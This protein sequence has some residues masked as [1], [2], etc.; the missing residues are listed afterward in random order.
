MCQA[1]TQT[2][3]EYPAR[4][5]LIV[6]DGRVEWV[7]EDVGAAGL[8]VKGDPGRGLVHVLAGV[9]KKSA[10]LKRAGS[11][12]EKARSEARSLAVSTGRPV[13]VAELVKVDTGDP[14]QMLLFARYLAEPIQ[15]D[16][17][18][19]VAKGAVG[20]VIQLSGLR[21]VVKEINPLTP[22]GFDALQIKLADGLMKK[23]APVSRAE[24][25]KLLYSLDV[26]WVNSTDAE[27]RILSER[28]NGAMRQVAGQTWTGVR[29]TLYHTGE[30]I[31]DGTRRATINRWDMSI[32]ANFKQRDLEAIRR[33]TA[34][35]S[36]YVTNFYTKN[37]AKGMSAEAR[38][39][40]RN[41]LAKGLGSRDIGERLYKS[42]GDYLPGRN[43]AYFNVVSSAF[44]NR[45]R[46]Y[47]QLVTFSDGGVIL[48]IWDSVL[49]E[50]TTPTCRYM[51]N[52]VFNVERGLAQYAAVDA[53]S[54]PQEV[55]F[56]QPWIR[57]RKIKGGTD[58]GKLGLFVPQRDGKSKLLAI[59]ERSGFG[60]KDDVGKWTSK[61]PGNE[62]PADV[63]A[64]PI[65]GL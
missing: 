56:I 26:D 29:G 32:S 44:V 30:R 58:D 45:S 62:V 59:Q 39:I 24:V 21:P 23:V 55:K 61:T 3:I 53:A 35:Q 33:V 18:V 16:V 9:G 64:P 17:L 13:A 43:R 31:A 15:S 63:G 37:V 52:R 48:T 7:G 41:G 1:C 50:V 4:G 25:E 54:D 19:E 38:T 22:A 47:S 49:D 2:A 12:L 34:A 8:L 5:A 42:L 28:I 10:R 46:T 51:Y 14:V 6:S 57:Q 20:H 40:V 36:H 60:K 27:L 65:H 11:D